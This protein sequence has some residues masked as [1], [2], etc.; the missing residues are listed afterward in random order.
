M[1]SKPVL[2]AGA[3]TGTQ[4]AVTKVSIRSVEYRIPLG[5]PKTVLLLTGSN[6]LDAAVTNSSS[7]TLILRW[8]PSPK[9][10]HLRRRRPNP[11]TQL[12]IYLAALSPTNLTPARIISVNVCL[13]FTT[14]APTLDG[15]GRLLPATR[16]REKTRI[17][18]ALPMPMFHVDHRAEVFDCV[19]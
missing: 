3:G 9:T 12:R 18:S 2:L 14:S 11:R 17:S 6:G 10:Q 4:V 13:I 7:Q 16:L 8:A 15:L 19:T 5:I 1:L